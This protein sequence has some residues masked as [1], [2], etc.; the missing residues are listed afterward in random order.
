MSTRSAVDVSRLR[1]TFAAMFREATSRVVTVVWF[2]FLTLVCAGVGAENSNSGV[3]AAALE[4]AR[5]DPEPSFHLQVHRTDQDGM[6]S[7]ELFPS[8][9]AV[10][11]GDTQ[12]H[13]DGEIRSEMIA[14]S[15][16]T[17]SFIWNRYMEARRGPQKGRCGSPAG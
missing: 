8:G 15:S 12:I 4:E 2:G 1:Y 3:L 11:H 7:L 10:W 9:V 6:R 13:L 14:T 17:T 5:S 16:D